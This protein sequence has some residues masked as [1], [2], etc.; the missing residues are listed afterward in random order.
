M[1]SQKQIEQQLSFNQ[2]LIKSLK[3][4]FKRQVKY[5]PKN[6]LDKLHK[7]QIGPQITVSGLEQV[8]SI[9][10]NLYISNFYLEE[11]LKDRNK[12]LQIYS[13]HK[14]KKTPSPNYHNTATSINTNNKHTNDKSTIPNKHIDIK[15]N[16]PQ[17]QSDKNN[18]PTIKISIDDNSK[19]SISDKSLDAP[20][21]QDNNPPPPQSSIKL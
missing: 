18:S 20:I 8:N 13:T 14:N 9:L 4:Y 3:P 6:I 7:V 1:L 5:L 17:T 2:D 11:A 10:K 19:Q 15:A 12:F 21:Q 16:F